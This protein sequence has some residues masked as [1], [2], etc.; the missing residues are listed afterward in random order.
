MLEIP[1]Y[2]WFEWFD[3][4]I[5]F[6]E[7]CAKDIPPPIMPQTDT[8]VGCNN[9]LPLAAVGGECVK[10]KWFNFTALLCCSKRFRL[11][12]FSINKV[13]G[14]VYKFQF[15]SIVGIV[16]QQTVLSTLPGQKFIAVLDSLTELEKNLF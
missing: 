6:S 7:K 1:F 5:S 14:D 3:T 9:D 10:E 8:P 4:E 11:P 12:F 2:A 16:S 13:I 15:S